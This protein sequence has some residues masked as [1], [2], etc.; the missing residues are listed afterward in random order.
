MPTAPGYLRIRVAGKTLMTLRLYADPETGLEVVAEFTD[1]TA[2]SNSCER[3]V[4]LAA[5][6]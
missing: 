6:R 4:V 3:D 2:I 1:N 5:R